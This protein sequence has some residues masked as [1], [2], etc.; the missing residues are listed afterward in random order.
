[1]ATILEHAYNIR[2][3]IRA[4]QG[5]SQDE[6][7]SL[8]NIQ[9]WIKAYRAKAITVMTDYGKEIDQQLV[10][11]L[12]VLKLEEVDAAESCEPCIEWGCP[13]LKVRLPKLVALPKNRSLLFVGKIDKQTPIKLDDADVSIYKRSAKF[14]N[15]FT[16]AYMI[17]QSLYVVPNKKDYDMRYIN[18]RGI[19]EDPTEVSKFDEDC[20]EICFNPEVDEYPLPMDYYDFIITNIMQKELRVLM[21]S[22][23][24]EFNNSRPDN[25]QAIPDNR[26]PESN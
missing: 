15:L 23:N 18:V 24:D 20:N 4:G 5:S 12:G 16:R 19:F 8:R 13:V 14:G 9:F 1:M 3:L 21:A 10:Q 7:L 6:R 17:G 2:N 11:D 25:E 26:R 22:Q